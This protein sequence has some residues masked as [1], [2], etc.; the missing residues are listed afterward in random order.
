MGLDDF[1]F[2]KGH[3]YGTL[4]CDLQSKS[5]LA[6]LPDR[7]PETVTAWLT[8][9]PYIKVVSRDGFT[10]FRQGISNASTSITQIYDRWHFIKNAKKQLDSFLSTLVPATIT[11]SEPKQPSQ[12]IP[13]T[14]AEQIIKNRSDKSGSLFKRFNTHI[15]MV[16]IFPDLQENIN[17]V[18]ELYRNI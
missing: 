4:I 6:L 2:R 1:A 8:K 5:P 18:E 14:R 15:K 10:G 11:W 3:T 13:L 12:E 17:L 9:H 16:K 7:L